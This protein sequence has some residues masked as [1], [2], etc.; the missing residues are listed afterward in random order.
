MKVLVCGGR[1]YTNREKVFQIL[2]AFHL[3]HNISEII[4]GGA[5]GA[6]YLASQWANEN[7]IFNM[8]YSAN[9]KQ[10]GKS[11]GAARNIKMLREGK[12][13]CVIAFPGGSGTQH[14]IS[15][16]KLAGLPIYLID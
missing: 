15:Q 14:M 9:W 1:T 3:E 7:K 2:S 4:Q 8:Q 12:P 5:K 6:D 16:A 10:Y 13:N 11:A